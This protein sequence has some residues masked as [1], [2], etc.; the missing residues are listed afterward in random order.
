MIIT[1]SF[2]LTECSHV[3]GPTFVW[4]CLG[5]HD[6]RVSES[7]ICYMF[8]GP[9]VA[10]NG[11]WLNIVNKKEGWWISRAYLKLLGS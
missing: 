8:G 3:V 1:T 11:G 9:P 4:G 10:N 6:T 2:L 7:V 5:R